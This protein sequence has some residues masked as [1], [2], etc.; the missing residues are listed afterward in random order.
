[1]PD[2]IR[3]EPDHRERVRP[4]RLAVVEVECAV[5]MHEVG[6]RACPYG[7][8]RLEIFESDIP[9]AMALVADP[10]ETR[11]EAGNVTEV[12]T[13]PSAI[14]RAH[15][16]LQEDKDRFLARMQIEHPRK[17]P[18]G[19]PLT[20]AHVEREYKGAFNWVEQ[21]W[22]REYG[23]AEGPARGVLPLRRVTVIERGL[24]PPLSEDEKRAKIV[25]ESANHHLADVMAQALAQLQG[26]V[27]APTNKRRRRG[28]D[29]DDA[30]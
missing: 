1:M 8:H 29:D 10:V 20:W 9:R 17:R 6:G 30:S 23:A 22:R 3:Y 18:D 11:D 19:Q 7:T 26:G 25:T 5:D 2:L 21:Y 14:E 16:S 24:P 4:E 12:K 15:A 13:D 27:T 28:S